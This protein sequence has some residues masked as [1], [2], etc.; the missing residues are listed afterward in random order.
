[1]SAALH[2]SLLQRRSF[3]GQFSIEGIAAHLARDLRAAGVDAR[4]HVAPVH[5]R[6]LGPRLAIARFARAHQGDVTHITGDITFAAPALRAARTVVTFHDCEPLEWMR[7]P[8]REVLRRFWYDAPARHAAAVT[9]DLAHT[10]ARLLVHVPGLE[11]DKV[12]VVPN[13]VAPVFRPRPQPPREG[14]PVVLQVGTKHN[15]NVPRLLA[16]LEGLDVVLHIVGPV[17]AALG[18]DLARRRIRHRVFQD[19]TETAL[20]E[21]YAAANVVAFASLAEGFGMPVIEA[22]A[23]GRPVVTSRTTSL[24]EVAGAGA[25]F[26]DPQDVGDIRAALVR[27]LGDACWR[28]R[29]VEAGFANARRFTRERVVAL[30][31]AL[32]RDLAEAAGPAAAYGRRSPPHPPPREAR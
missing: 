17:D 8:R 27:V 5:S 25:H 12:H 9:A 18:A 31:G 30:Y 24:P 20:A 14:P 19:L 21:C 6:G 10:K 13:A 15:K 28:A 16:A 1:M 2:V 29:L 32:Y 26:V 23:M 22:Q 7:G 4:L 11:P 3:A